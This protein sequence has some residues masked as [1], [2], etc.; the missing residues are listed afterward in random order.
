MEKKRNWWKC[1]PQLKVRCSWNFEHFPGKWKFGKKS[2]LLK[3]S[4]QY[5]ISNWKLWMKAG[6]RLIHGDGH[7]DSRC[8]R[9]GWRT[10]EEKQATKWSRSS[11][12]N[13]IRRTTDVIHSDQN[14]KKHLK[15]SRLLS[16]F[17]RA[18]AAMKP[19]LLGSDIGRANPVA[20]TVTTQNHVFSLYDHYRS[21]G[22][23]SSFF[24]KPRPMSDPCRCNMAILM[25]VKIVPSSM[26]RSDGRHKNLKCSSQF[27]SL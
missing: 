11:K 9:H 21:R 20:K 12:I 13:V 19:S 17:S 24:L 7:C 2:T 22:F 3:M 18:S 5:I 8:W 6:A 25:R 23:E 4:S 15:F 27:W 14:C 16:L 10:W 26:K 1:E